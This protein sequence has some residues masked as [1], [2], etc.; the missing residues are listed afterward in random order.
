MNLLQKWSDGL[1]VKALDSQSRG[2]VFKTT[3]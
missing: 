2:P 3:G 1:A